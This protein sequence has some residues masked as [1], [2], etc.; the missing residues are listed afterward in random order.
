MKLKKTI[1]STLAGLAVLG[2]GLETGVRTHDR[3]LS[4][5][6][7]ALEQQLSQ[8]SMYN[9][10]VAQTQNT[11]KRIYTGAVVDYGLPLYLRLSSK[12]STEDRKE[13]L[14][15]H[16]DTQTGQ[17]RAYTPEEQAVL[18]HIGAN[19]NRPNIGQLYMLNSLTG[20]AFQKP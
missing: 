6:S 8:N 2:L 19:P 18:W 12:Y 3:M 14:Q 16:T 15:A 13:I 11:L 17:L 5:P 10:I 4:K 7:P 9:E 1:L 20:S